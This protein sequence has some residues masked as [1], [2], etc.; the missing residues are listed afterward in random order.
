MAEAKPAGTFNVGRF[1][2]V[3]LIAVLIFLLVIGVVSITGLWN[4]ILLEPMLNFL[5]LMS[6]YFLGSFG[7]AVLVLTIVIRLLVFPLTMRQLKSSRA[8]QAIQP[9]IR[10]VQKKYAKDTPQLLAETSRIY[11]EARVNPFGCALPML[12]QFPI[13]IALYQSILQDLAYTPENLLGLSKQ[14]YSS[15]VIQGAV[16]LGHHFLSLDLN[17]GSIFMAI[18]SAASMW[19]LQ[20]MSA[21]PTTDPQ[22]QTTNRIMLWAFPLMFG[23]FAL[24][25]PAGLSLYWVFSNIISIVIQYPVTG[26]GTLKMPS[27]AFLKRGA[28]QPAGNPQAKSGGTAST[29]KKAGKSAVPEQSGAKKSGASSKKKE[30]AGGDIIPRGNKV[31]HEERGGE[32]KD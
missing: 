32:R 29:G 26:W 31:G 15:A 2:I 30:T 3:L 16:P 13:W 19:M 27:L 4:K 22:Q 20:K 21:Q 11:K 8:M 12:I 9:K 17:S 23:L 7:I 1:V 18:L 6:R 10:E 25:L 24:S 14:M 5:L 28:P